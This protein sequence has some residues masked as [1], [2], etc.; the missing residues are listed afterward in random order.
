VG[1]T[2]VVAAEK[3]V[4]LRKPLTMLLVAAL[5]VITKKSARAH[6]HNQLSGRER[7]ID[8]RLTDLLP[9]FLTGRHVQQNVPPPSISS[10]SDAVME[11]EEEKVLVISRALKVVTSASDEILLP[12]REMVPPSTVVR[13]VSW[14]PML[15]CCEKV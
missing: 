4:E 1:P 11:A 3:T 7:V 6:T 12:A 5:M 15:A 8:V 10:V 14:L 2:V 9:A 13:S